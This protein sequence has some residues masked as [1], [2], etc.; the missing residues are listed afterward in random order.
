MLTPMLPLSRTPSLNCVAANRYDKY[1]G[2]SGDV[3]ENKGT[4]LRTRGCY[5][6]LRPKS[7]LRPARTA[8]APVTGYPGKVLKIKDHFG[9]ELAR[10][11]RCCYQGGR[12]N[13]PLRARAVNAPITEYPGNMLKGKG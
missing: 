5:S 2:A 1:S 10:N 13:T 3:I 11:G 4:A 9:M 7:V 6:A 8:N 12:G